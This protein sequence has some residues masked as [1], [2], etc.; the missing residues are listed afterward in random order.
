[1]VK[2]EPGVRK[3]GELKSLGLVDKGVRLISS[4]RGTKS[5]LLVMVS[6]EYFGKRNSPPLLMEVWQDGMMGILCLWLS[7]VIYDSH[8][9]SLFSLS[10]WLS[11]YEA[12]SI[13]GWR[14]EGN[15]KGRRKD[16]SKLV[17]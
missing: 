3:L 10:T 4:K 11:P 17:E 12:D 8:K 13:R 9:V 16:Q 15:G 14:R 7:Q 5:L 2:G 6:L 1:M